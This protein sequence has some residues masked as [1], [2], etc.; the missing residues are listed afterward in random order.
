MSLL[1]R[2][3]QQRQLR[4]T[5]GT[6]KDIDPRQSS[7]NEQVSFYRRLLLEE[8]DLEELSKLE[9]TQRRVRLE[10]ILS[11][12]LSQQGP[13]L[14]ARERSQLIQRVVDESLGLGILEPLLAD[15]SITEIMVNGPN[16]IFVERAGRLEKLDLSFSNDEQLMQVIDLSLIHI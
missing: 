2:A 16:T 8:V 1:K 5:L 7:F 10:R 11:H 14:S 9:R 12:L 3:E 15:E 4:G 6:D 13:V